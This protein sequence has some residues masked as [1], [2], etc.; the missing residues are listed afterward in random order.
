[1]KEVAETKLGKKVKKASLPSLPISTTISAKL[2]K[3][4]VPLPTSKSFE[5]SMNPRRQ[6]SPTVL[7]LANLRRS[8][9]F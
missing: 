4:L 7:V 8:E 5:S 6:P 1:M 3:T 2:R 9:M